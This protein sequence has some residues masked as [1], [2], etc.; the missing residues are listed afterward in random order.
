MVLAP[1][2]PPQ[3]SKIFNEKKQ[4]FYPAVPYHLDTDPP[5]TQ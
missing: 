1:K 2:P 5:E 3:K 4:G